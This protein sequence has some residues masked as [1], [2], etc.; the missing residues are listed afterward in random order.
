LPK[1]ERW[2]KLFTGPLGQDMRDIICDGKKDCENE[3]HHSNKPH[4]QVK[5]IC[6]AI[7]DRKIKVGG[8]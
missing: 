7:A 8:K 2:E 6:R 5:K 3:C 4:C 1:L